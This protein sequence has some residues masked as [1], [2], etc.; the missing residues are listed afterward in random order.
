MKTRETVPVNKTNTVRS[1]GKAKI[2]FASTTSIVIACFALFGAG[3]TTATIVCSLNH[4]MEIIELKMNYSREIETIRM[5]NKGDRELTEKEFE[6]FM[7]NYNKFKNEK[8]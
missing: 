1:R 5:S 8:K 7:D 4:R 3:Y 2:N 6:I